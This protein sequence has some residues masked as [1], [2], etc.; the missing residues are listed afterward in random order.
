MAQ[1]GTVAKTFVGLASPHQRRAGAGGWPCQGIWYAAAGATPRVAMIA[2]HY[3]IDFSQHYLAELMAER[4]IGF[5][6]WN[7]RFRG[8]EAHFLLDHALVDIGTGVRW[9]RAEQGVQTVVLLGNSGGGSLMSAYQSHAV[10]PNV[11]PLP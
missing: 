9:L 8:D 7:T 6:G 10:S 1:S 4:G 2:T 3:N 5:L 11:L